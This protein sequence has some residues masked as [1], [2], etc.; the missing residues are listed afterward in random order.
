MHSGHVEWARPYGA[1]NLGVL[2]GMLSKGRS[3]WHDKKLKWYAGHCPVLRDACKASRLSKPQGGARV[4]YTPAV[5]LWAAGVVLYVLLGGYPPFYDES[6]PE[7]FRLIRKGDYRFD[8]PVWETIS[9]RY[10][11]AGHRYIC[12]RV[13]VPWFRI[14]IK[15]FQ[16]MNKCPPSLVYGCDEWLH[17]TVLRRPS[18]SYSGVRCQCRGCPSY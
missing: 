3:L 15:M 14:S 17:W 16:M 5:D 2:S 10:A 1:R 13:Q 8:D 7:L 4:V 9:D 6:E 18:F 11:E 12:R